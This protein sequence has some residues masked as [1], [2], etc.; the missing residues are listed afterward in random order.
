[1]AYSPLLLVGQAN[2]CSVLEDVLFRYVQLCCMCADL[3]ALQAP[4]KFGPC[5][6]FSLA[7]EYVSPLFTLKLELCI[8]LGVPTYD[9]KT[10]QIAGG[11]V[12]DPVALSFT[13]TLVMRTPWRFASW[14]TLKESGF[15][16]GVGPQ[17][18]TTGIPAS[19]GLATGAVIGA[20]PKTW[21][22]GSIAVWVPQT[23]PPLISMRASL[24]KF[25]IGKLIRAFYEGSLGFM[26][27][28]FDAFWMEGIFFQVSTNPT[29]SVCPICPCNPKLDSACPTVV[30]EP[31]FM[32]AVEKFSLFNK[33]IGG[34]FISIV[35]T[36]YKINA[37]IQKFTLGPF[38]FGPYKKPPNG[39]DRPGIGNVLLEEEALQEEA[40]LEQSV[41]EGR[42]G[43]DLSHTWQPTELKG[44]HRKAQMD[45]YYELLDKGE[46][47]PDGSF[48]EAE[49]VDHHKMTHH[50]MRFSDVQGPRFHDGRLPSKNK[51]VT[52]SPEEWLEK[53]EEDL[54]LASDLSESIGVGSQIKSQLHGAL[55]QAKTQHQQRLEQPLVPSSSRR[56]QDLGA[57]LSRKASLKQVNQE[58]A[59]EIQ[60]KNQVAH[61]EMKA[62]QNVST[63]EPK[64]PVDCEQAEWSEWY[65]PVN[66]GSRSDAPG[67]SS[68]KSCS[69][70]CGGGFQS[71][72]RRIIRP[73]ANGGKPCL[74]GTQASQRRDCN[75]QKC[76]DRCARHET[77]EVPDP[78][79]P[80]A[81][82][83]QR[84]KDVCGACTSDPE[85]GYCPLTGQCKTGQQTGPVQGSC[86]GWEFE[87]CNPAARNNILA[88]QRCEKDESCDK[89]SS[90][91][92]HC[93]RTTFVSCMQ[94]KQSGC[95]HEGT[96]KVMDTSRPGPGAIVDT[97]CRHGRDLGSESECPRDYSKLCPDGWIK[98]PDSLTPDIVGCTPREGAYGGVCSPKQNFQ[99]WNASSKAE[100]AQRCSAVW[101]CN[102]TIPKVPEPETMPLV[103][104][105]GSGRCI[106]RQG[107]SVK[108]VDTRLV[109]EQCSLRTTKNGCENDEECE[110][111]G[112]CWIAN[113]KCNFFKD[114]F[115][116]LFEVPYL[117]YTG[118][119]QAGPNTPQEQ[120]KCENSVR[121]GGAFDR[122][123]IALASDDGLVVTIKQGK[124]IGVSK[125]KQDRALWKLKAVPNMDET[126]WL[127]SQQGCETQSAPC[128]QWVA[129]EGT[130]SLKLVPQNNLGARTRFEFKPVK[131]QNDHFDLVVQG[132][133][134]SP[135]SEGGGRRLMS[136]VQNLARVGGRRLLGRDDSGE[137]N[138]K[139][140][141][142]EEKNRESA[143]KLEEEKFRN[144]QKQAKQKEGNNKKRCKMAQSNDLKARRADNTALFGAQWNEMEKERSAK[145]SQ[146]YAKDNHE[147]GVK[148]Q[149]KKAKTLERNT[150]QSKKY[151]KIEQGEREKQQQM[152][153][154]VDQTDKSYQ[155]VKAQADNADKAREQAIEKTAA[156]EREMKK[157]DAEY[158]VT[159][160]KDVKEKD[161]KER[162]TKEKRAKELF[163]QERA[164]KTEDAKKCKVDELKIKQELL[165][166]TEKQNAASEVRRQHLIGELRDCV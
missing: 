164:Q 165:M 19:I 41:K 135:C 110:W 18:F 108:M 137:R 104:E 103:G 39:L 118:G 161:T 8:E 86:L 159:K 130:A 24:N 134:D 133:D 69:Q 67:A 2:H 89:S 98:Q 83:K 63:H 143:R 26:E 36:R 91:K 58:Q 112:T 92:A 43:R 50:N 156:T 52:E 27:S 126:Y 28:V 88:K 44:S 51:H 138:G 157:K 33:I 23:V 125:S 117:H 5:Y 31:G 122:A 30:F 22:E 68:G 131:G 149:E 78:K 40:L 111:V 90:W 115:D 162:D 56:L 3:T 116:G 113:L 153:Q 53:E 49:H 55:K 21:I 66:Q 141:E 76:T 136:I 35:P 145:T 34:V 96:Y 87:S 128:G 139:Q 20:N 146:K 65:A 79:Q 124:Q 100:W 99:D 45:K 129:V 151:A 60:Q 121:G 46:I 9:G 17:T 25:G 47:Y 54:G 61:Q 11:V 6:A 119:C 95:P 85:C 101:P 166:E 29:A 132:S 59:N 71:R 163:R 14:F 107:K 77:C 123:V 148:D 16:I 105:P 127:Q 62:S 106:A 74:T 57:E 140:R 158:V 160:E 1:M 48:V 70:D 142:K 73:A 150:K 42:I 114:Q 10:I 80:G 13:F 97:K 154:G 152:K 37:W 120:P 93:Q 144:A 102:L 109:A 15:A 12:I 94:V 72:F 4:A 64:E 81:V 82:L 7:L 75:T 155:T 84:C 38:E 32:F 147:N